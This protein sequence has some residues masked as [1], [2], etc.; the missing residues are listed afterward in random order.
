M[1]WIKVK[2]LLLKLWCSELLLINMPFVTGE[3]QDKLKQKLAREEHPL[4]SFL[5]PSFP[6]SSVGLE[7]G[8]LFHSRTMHLLL[9]GTPQELTKLTKLPILGRNPRGFRL[10]LT[11]EEPE[12]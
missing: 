3:K 2:C 1:V 8:L 12:P 4:R 6:D 9:Q 7:I 11:T 10:T 5:N